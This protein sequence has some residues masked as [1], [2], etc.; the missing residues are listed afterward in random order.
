MKTVSNVVIEMTNKVIGVEDKEIQYVHK[1]ILWKKK[2]K[3]KIIK[4]I[5]VFVEEILVGNI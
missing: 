2:H 4:Y 1:W 5:W 3:T